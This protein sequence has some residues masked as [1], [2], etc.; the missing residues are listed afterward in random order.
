MTWSKRAHIMDL[1]WV[2]GNTNTKF[3][4]ISTHW[5]Q[6]QAEKLKFCSKT[7]E[8]FPNIKKSKNKL[9]CP[10]R[11]DFN[12]GLFVVGFVFFENSKIQKL[13]NCGWFPVSQVHD[14]WEPYFSS[15]VTARATLLLRCKRSKHRFQE[16]S[17]GPQ[18]LL[19]F[20]HATPSP[21]NTSRHQ[22][23]SM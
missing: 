17:H 18:T 23:T 6:T 9:E 12:A 19:H 21:S 10:E 3:S 4:N 22:T 11:N 5:E 2:V 1:S 13:K 7:F 16:I 15:C 8:S 14:C 20:S